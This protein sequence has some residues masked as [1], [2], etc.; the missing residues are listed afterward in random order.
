MPLVS[1]LFDV[2]YLHIVCMSLKKAKVRRKRMARTCNALIKCNGGSDKI[3][4]RTPIS[5]ISTK[6]LSKTGG[7][8]RANKKPPV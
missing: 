4:G 8:A 5:H 3:H 6:V 1:L 7:V 2:T